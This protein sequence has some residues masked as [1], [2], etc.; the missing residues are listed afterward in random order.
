MEFMLCFSGLRS[1]GRFGTCGS[2]PA[3]GVE[4]QR[5]VVGLSSGVVLPELDRFVDGFYN[6]RQL[7]CQIGVARP[8]LRWVRHL[9]SAL[10]LLQQTE[11]VTETAF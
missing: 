3:G 2:V 9:S 6:G 7:T 10:S 1:A 8:K 4:G 11:T 5:A